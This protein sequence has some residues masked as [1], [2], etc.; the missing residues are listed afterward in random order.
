M[1]GVEHNQYE[2]SRLILT[3]AHKNTIPNILAAKKHVKINMKDKYVSVQ[4]ES[5]EKP[6]EINSRDPKFRIFPW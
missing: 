3:V 6:V 2:A 1:V 5:D 4:K